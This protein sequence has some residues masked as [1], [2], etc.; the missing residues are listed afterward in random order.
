MKLLLEE[1]WTNRFHPS[2]AGLRECT[3]MGYESA[4]RIHIQP[5]L[6]GCE[7]GELDVM[8]IEE[9]LASIP[10]R[11]G[12]VKA[13]GV[14]RAML[15]KAVRWG[16]LDHDVTVM[17]KAP[18][19]PD[20][21]P[22]LLDM[23]QIRSLL[24][25]FWGHDLE[26]WL[27][28]SVTLGLRPEEAHGLEWADINLVS[29]E[30]RIHHCVQW[31]AGR[32]VVVDPKTNLSRRKLIL[33]RF[34]VNRLRQLKGK[35]RLVGELNP[36]QVDRRY[37][38]WCRRNDLPFVPRRNLRHSWA[39]SAL[40]AGVDVAVVSRAL[41]HSSIQTTARYYLRPDLAVLKDAQ[42]VWEKALMNA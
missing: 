15:R 5:K 6:G 25:G 38:A 39:T 42:K 9:W 12:A 29:G 36:G 7:L 35:G 1:F 33:P 27:I 2:C 20:R 11:G 19:K 3:R 4:W 26:A 22:D 13:W 21:Q 34:A 17:V 40:A 8:R 28:C 18:R 37:R 23:G 31:L 32:E 30:T 14:L 24:Q 16:L 41:G 10:T